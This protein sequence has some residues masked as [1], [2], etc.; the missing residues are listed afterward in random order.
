MMFKGAQRRVDDLEKFEVRKVCE[1]WISNVP[2]LV[3]DCKEASLKCC[4]A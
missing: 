1:R 2:T 3:D 4:E